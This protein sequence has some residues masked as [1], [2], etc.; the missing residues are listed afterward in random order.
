MKFGPGPPAQS[1]PRRTQCTSEKKKEK[2]KTRDGETQRKGNL[3][4]W[5][6]RDVGCSRMLW[7]Q[8]PLLFSL[9][10]SLFVITG[11]LKM[12]LWMHRQVLHKLLRVRLRKCSWSFI[13]AL[14]WQIKFYSVLSVWAGGQKSVSYGNLWTRSNKSKNDPRERGRVGGKR[15]A[16]TSC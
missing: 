9:H 10:K 12:P 5:S 2:R 15:A 3:F 14:A 1:H 16:C 6:S 4:T 13:A 7:R 11:S 8:L